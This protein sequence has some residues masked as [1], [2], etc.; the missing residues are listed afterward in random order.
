LHK[1]MVVGIGNYI[2]QDEGVGVHAINRLMK[3]DLP[4][5]VELLDGGTHSY[6][7]VDFFCQAEKLIIIDAIQAGGEPG[8]MYRAPLEEMGLQPQENCTSLHQMHFIEAVKMVNLLGH[9]PQIIVYG[10]EPEVVDWGLELTPRVAEKLP[11]LTEMIA[12]EISDLMAH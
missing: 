3:M 5:D 7:L 8:T 4:S 9:Y 10:I 11:R 12:Q 1:L 6:D 2:L